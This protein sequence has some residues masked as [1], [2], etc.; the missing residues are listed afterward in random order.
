MNDAGTR[1]A[2][3]AAKVAAERT[4][5]DAARAEDPA[6]LEAI[7][8]ADQHAG[9]DNAK[10][11]RLLNERVEELRSKST[12]QRTIAIRAADVPTRSFKIHED[13]RYLANQRQLA[14]RTQGGL[15]VIGG[16]RVKAGEFL[17]CVAVGSDAQWGCTGTLIGP[18]VVLTAGHCAGV[19]TRIFIG[20]DVGKE[21]RIVR[22]KKR[23][24]HPDYHKSRHNDLLVLLLDSN[25]DDVAPRLLAKKTLL[26]DATDGRVVGFGATDASGHFGYGVKRFVDVPIASPD[27][28]GQVDGQSDN[29]TYGC[30]PGLELVAGR[31]M[32]EKDSCKGDSGGP[33]YVMNQTQQWLLGAVTSR[34]TDSAMHTCGDGGV[35][36]RV[37]RYRAWIA[38]IPG[39]VLA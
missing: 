26:D 22:V 31:P 37:D 13:P 24:R 16:K 34:A 18:N 28:R 30:D 39:V 3:G 7:E 14:R 21:G 36:P 20:N 25:V 5:S 33:F 32:L 23:V 19:A 12:R 8:Y 17:D 9:R 29:T 38:A 4:S 35:Y 27:C 10:F 11:E 1:R 15:R 6:L 2:R